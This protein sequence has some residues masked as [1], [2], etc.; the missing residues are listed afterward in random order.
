MAPVFVPRVEPTMELSTALY[1]TYSQLMEMSNMEYQF[2]GPG[3]DGKVD[4]FCDV[5]K[6]FGDLDDSCEELKIANDDAVNGF[7]PIST[8]IL[9]HYGQNYLADRF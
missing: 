8:K 1:S 7:G 2:F 4:G 9:K 3:H 5:V 6:H